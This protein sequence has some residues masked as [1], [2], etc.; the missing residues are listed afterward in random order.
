MAQGVTPAD[1]EDTIQT[2]RA[3]FLS[4]YWETSGMRVL[5][6]GSGG[7]R[8]S[9]PDDLVWA[10]VEAVAPE[11]RACLPWFDAWSPDDETAFDRK[12]AFEMLVVARSSRP[13][14]ETYVRARTEAEAQCLETVLTR[15][16]LPRLLPADATVV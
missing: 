11:L 13:D 12:F 1:F 4:G 2:L 8:I 3:K 14:V 16:P 10:S 9:Y 6:V 15:I 5:S 7:T